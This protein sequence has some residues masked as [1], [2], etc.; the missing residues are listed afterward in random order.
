MNMLKDL[1]LTVLYERK[2]VLGSLIF[3]LFGYFGTVQL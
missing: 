3:F 2:T 1:F